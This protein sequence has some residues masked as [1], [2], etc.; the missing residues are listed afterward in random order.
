ML[1]ELLEHSVE[2]FQYIFDYVIYTRDVVTLGHISS[3]CKQL[4]ALKWPLLAH[5]RHYNKSLKTIE[6]IKRFQIFQD[7]CYKEHV[8]F[9]ELNDN[10]T[11]YAV[12]KNIIPEFDIFS[13]KMHHI[14]IHPWYGRIKIVY[15]TTTSNR[16][17]LKSCGGFNLLPQWLNKYMVKGSKKIIARIDHNKF[18]FDVD[19]Y[20]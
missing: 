11:I 13:S 6:S 12:A 20:C 14:L 4:Y 17:R 1:L 8:T 7:G 18:G 3:V 16:Y 2:I 15:I 5:K 9:M 19:Y 10:L